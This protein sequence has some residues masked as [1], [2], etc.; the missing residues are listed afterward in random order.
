[1]NSYITQNIKRKTKVGVQNTEVEEAIVKEDTI[2]IEEDMKQNDINSQ[3]EQ[4]TKKLEILGKKDTIVGKRLKEEKEAILG[5]KLGELE[6][7]IT[8]EK[9]P[10]EKRDF[11]KTLLEKYMNKA[12]KE[13]SEDFNFEEMY[14]K[15]FGDVPSSL[16]KKELSTNEMRYAGNAKSSMLS[17][18]EGIEYKYVGTAFSTYIMLEIGND[19]YLLDQH[20]AH[21]RILYERVKKN[22]YSNKKDAQLMLLPD[23]IVLTNKEYF[24][25]RENQN[26]FEEAG[27]IIEEF[28]DNTIKLVGVPNMCIDLDTKM[29]F[30]DILDEIDTV[31]RTER[32]EIEEKFIATIAC[33]AAVKAKSELG[34]EEIISLL[35]QLMKLKNPFTCPHGR[36]TAIKL[37][38]LD[39]EKKFSRR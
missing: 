9:K 26:I 34:R 36:P 21:E 38:K 8:L 12:V 18:E 31:A 20:A 27:F 1:M 11:R 15:T 5:E 39:I 23:V 19:L 25:M 16:K 3:P 10:E 24:I 13:D 30:L 32:Q 14:T 4:L 28:G 2:P 7:D 37:S 17:K 6:T 22:F 35:D 33:K 29:L